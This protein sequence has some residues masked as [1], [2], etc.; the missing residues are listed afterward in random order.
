MDCVR[1]GIRDSGLEM[2]ETR[3]ETRD[4]RSGIRDMGFLQKAGCIGA[5]VLSILGSSGCATVANTVTGAPAMMR[6][7][8]GAVSESRKEELT[9]NEDVIPFI[10]QGNAYV[11][12]PLVLSAFCVI[13]GPFMGA[14]SGLGADVHFL[15]HGR[16]PEGYS[17]FRT[18]S[19]KFFPFEQYN[20][21]SASSSSV[22]NPKPI[23]SQRVASDGSVQ[24]LYT[25][26]ANHQKDI[27]GFSSG[28]KRK[29][30]ADGAKGVA[31]FGSEGFEFLG[32]S[33]HLN[34][35]DHSTAKNS[36]NRDMVK[37]SGM[38]RIFDGWSFLFSQ[39]K[40][41]KTEHLD[42]ST[43]TSTNIE[44][45]DFNSLFE[46]FFASMGSLIINTK[47]SFSIV[48]GYSRYTYDDSVTNSTVTNSKWKGIYDNFGID[49]TYGNPSA[50][51]VSGRI[52]SEN[53]SGTLSKNGQR[54]YRSLPEPHSWRYDL[55]LSLPGLY[56]GATAFS[57]DHKEV[58]G[59]YS[60]G[61][62]RL[63][64]WGER[65]G[66]SLNSC[67]SR[68]NGT[69]MYAFNK[70]D[71]S[72]VMRAEYEHKNIQNLSLGEYISDELKSEIQHALLKGLEDAV[73]ELFAEQ[74]PGDVHM[75]TGASLF[76]PFGD[77]VYAS[78]T[79]TKYFR[80]S[81]SG[82]MGVE[83]SNSHP[84]IN[85]IDFKS[86][87]DMVFVFAK[88]DVDEKRAISFGMGYY[89]PDPADSV[90]MTTASTKN[91]YSPQVDVHA[92]IEWS[93]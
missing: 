15:K 14:L 25:L 86:S 38:I 63:G 78:R 43:S 16:Y 31:S 28:Y 69:I 53:W 90:D 13:A 89:D 64:L 35:S 18:H 33:E 47:N 4:M 10:S 20:V 73:V 48:G 50:S 23:T 62:A 80:L 22:S 9:K 65:V 30:G 84:F 81:A 39:E 17:L 37:Q 36:S 41:K 58:N 79:R 8:P 61:G 87:F 7:I 70:D 2:R 49:Y 51:M 85:P 19:W 44:D 54:T 74:M 24:S 57:G 60:D 5:L 66:F 77:M 26:Y 34:G 59:N 46:T 71:I 92:Q 68:F 40:T 29:Y 1:N 82:D 83:P 52:L 45:R 72:R 12:S 55:D 93:F 67:N 21:P 27:G 75:R 3:C 56:I 88:N 6:N 32:T 76:L 91:I 11:G 42:S